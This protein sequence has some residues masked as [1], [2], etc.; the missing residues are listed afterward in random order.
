MV[1]NMFLHALEHAHSV[2][3]AGHMRPDG[4]CVGSCMGLYHYIQ[5]W[6]PNI[7]VDVYLEEIPDSFQFIQRTEEISHTLKKK[8]Y[9]LFVALD[10]GDS[11]RLGFAE[12]AFLHAKETICIDHHISNDAYG[13]YNYIQ[14]DAS[15][16]SELVYELLE[17]EKITKEI[18]E[19]LYLGIVHDTGVFQ[20]TCTSPQTMVAAADLM[21]KGIAYSRIITD[22]FYEKTYVQNQILGRALLESV[23]FMEG[24]CIASV[25]TKE[26]M[27][28]YGAKPKDL[29]GIVSQL[30]VTK[31]VKVAIFLYETEAGEFKISLRSDSD[32]DVSKIASYFGGGGHQK[33]A[34]I[35]MT[36]S[37]HDIIKS[38]SE[39]IEVALTEG[40]TE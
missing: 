11:K 36:G 25:I 14:P 1:N 4:D 31:G 28:F 27:D 26:T 12:E 34:G 30:R 16:T 33:A 3:I 29:E 37:A 13:K 5:T 8:A 17:H 23:L 6:Y 7:D 38:L 18:A 24:Q 32:V 21:S 22:T 19:C 20:Y 35:T 15:S 40:Q 10:C 39:K 9:D 2:A